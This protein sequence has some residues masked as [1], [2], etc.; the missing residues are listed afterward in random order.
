VRLEG[1]VAIITGAASGIGRAMARL[2]TTEGA[3]V[4]L[5]DLTEGRLGQVAAEL[6][7][8]GARVK[9]LTADVSKGEDTDRLVDTAIDA[10]GRVD[11]LCNNAGVLDNLTPAG[12]TDDA[13]WAKVMGVN[14]DGPFR[15]ARKVLPAMIA[16]GGG[17]IVNTASAAG[18]RGGRGGAAYTASKHALVGLTQSI[19]WFYGPQN[20]RCNAIAPGSI[21]TKM[22]T[23]VVP[24]AAGFQRTQPYIPLIPMP[25]K[26][27]E[28]AQV[29]LFLASD[30]SSYVN[31][32]ILP[33]DGG[34]ISY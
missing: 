17:S 10:F 20:V 25:G 2:F 32:A 12:E 3:A 7:A 1:K 22:Q 14:V 34:W 30:E 11:V 15:L 6:D 9:A 13:M 5:A 23:T 27:A 18:L 8:S 29:A 28:I 19:A 24:T 21:Q 16:Q 26:A 4:V 31:G 33:A